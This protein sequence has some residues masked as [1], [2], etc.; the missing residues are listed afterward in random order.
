STTAAPTSG[1]PAARAR[2]G[3]MPA[4]PGPLPSGPAP[5]APGPLPSGLAPAARS[6]PASELRSGPS[7]ATPR[8]PGAT[9]S[10]RSAPRPSLA[11]SAATSRAARS[12]ASPP[13]AAPAWAAAGW[14]TAACAGPDPR[15]GFPTTAAM[16]HGVTDMRRTP[17]RCQ[18]LHGARGLAAA[19]ALGAALLAAPVL[20]Q[21]PGQE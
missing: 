11:P 21:Q 7:R 19:L 16:G 6:L 20:A 18:P 3:P 12:G 14:R 15:P 10:R 4:G 17:A 9:P 5:A 13:G 2:P 1:R 8:P